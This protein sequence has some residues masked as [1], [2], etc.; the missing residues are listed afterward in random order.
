M[1]YIVPVPSFVSKRAENNVIV[2]F[3]QQTAN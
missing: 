3:I 2:I 1:L